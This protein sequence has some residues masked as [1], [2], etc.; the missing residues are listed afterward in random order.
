MLCCLIE[1]NSNWM[2][3]ALCYTSP[4]GINILCIICYIYSILCWLY[5]IRGVTVWGAVTCR[6]N[7]GLLVF[8]LS[9]FY[10]YILS[11]AYVGSLGSWE[12]HDSR[13]SSGPHGSGW[14]GA[15]VLT[16][17]TLSETRGGG[18]G[19]PASGGA[20]RQLGG[21]ELRAVSVF[22]LQRSN[23]GQRAALHKGRNHM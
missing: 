6:C 19:H 11:Q 9:V 21:H 23:T 2:H 18:G 12:P 1:L 7:K 13:L 3:H 22:I 15:T 17:G 20:T 4:I 16:R 5:Y 8:E 14:A 10:C